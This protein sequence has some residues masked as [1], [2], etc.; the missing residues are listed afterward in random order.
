VYRSGAI[1]RADVLPAPT[2][3]QLHRISSTAVEVSWDKPLYDSVLGYR[4]YYHTSPRADLVDWQSVEIGPYAVTEVGGLAPNAMYAFR[5]RARAADHR[6]GNLSDVVMFP[7]HD[8]GTHETDQHVTHRCCYLRRRLVG[9]NVLVRVCLSVGLS[10]G[11]RNNWKS[12]GRIF[13]KFGE[14]VQY[15]PDKS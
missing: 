15:E 9:D 12:Y 6:Y 14:Y 2:N 8:S 5:V 3:V 13:V 10:A 7:R 1:V 4:V 11:E